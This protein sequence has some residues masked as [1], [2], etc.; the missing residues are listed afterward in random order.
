[1]IPGRYYTGFRNA[2]RRTRLRLDLTHG[3][4]NELSDDKLEELRALGYAE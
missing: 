1:M 4:Q 3:P 2:W